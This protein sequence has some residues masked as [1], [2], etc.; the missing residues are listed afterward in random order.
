M[1]KDDSDIQETNFVQTS[2][3][4]NNDILSEIDN[5]ILKLK[6]KNKD[7][8]HT[9]QRWITAAIL[10]KINKGKKDKARN[11]IPPTKKKSHLSIILTEKA[12]N[13][14]EKDVLFYKTIDETYTKK[15][16]IL[17]AIKEKL[18]EENLV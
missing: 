2:I 16:W 13:D 3:K 9:K 18:E 5:S 6:E 8:K 14:F 11:K 10:D 7:L 4:L 1:K 15:K 12:Y 17:E